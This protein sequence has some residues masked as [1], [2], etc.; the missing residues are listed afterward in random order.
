MDKEVCEKFT[1]TPYTP[2]DSPWTQIF[3]LILIEFD[4]YLN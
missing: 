4:S 1:F 3:E 2:M